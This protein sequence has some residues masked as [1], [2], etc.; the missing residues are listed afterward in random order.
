MAT[1]PSITEVERNLLEIRQSATRKQV[2]EGRAWYP[3]MSRLIREITLEA[4]D[5][6]GEVADHGLAVGVFCAF[7]QNA[8][9]KANVTMAGNYLN[10]EGRG[11]R[12]VMAECEAME[13]GAHPRDVLGLKRSDFWSNLTGDYDRVTCDRWHLRAALGLLDAP[14]AKSIPL[15]PETHA[16]VTEATRRVSKR[17]R[18]TP[19]ATQAVI[20]CAVRG[21]GK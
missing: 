5:H 20:W 2:T 9:W 21:D 16:L 1:L 17:Y 3:A 18:E 4:F 15:T 19:A 13:N 12:S 14:K 8:T 10:G 11:M 6:V 7:S